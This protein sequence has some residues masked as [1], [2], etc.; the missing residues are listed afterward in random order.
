MCSRARFYIDGNGDSSARAPPRLCLFGVSLSPANGTP[1]LRPRC[2]RFFASLAVSA[3]QLTG[4]KHAVQ[5]QAELRQRAHRARPAESAPDCRAVADLVFVAG[6]QQQPADRQ[7]GK[8]DAFGHAAPV[9][10]G[11][12]NRAALFLGEQTPHD[13]S[14]ILPQL[15]E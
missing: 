1:A 8:R 9:C 15:G 7:A 13:L 10:A 5:Q 11:T 6:R 14:N 3:M 4:W 12:I 2:A